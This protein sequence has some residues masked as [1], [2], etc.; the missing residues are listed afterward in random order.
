MTRLAAAALAAAVA[1]TPAALAADPDRGRALYELR[2]G[3][4]HSK[5]VHGRQR[6]VAT[7]FAAVRGW[8]ARWSR[9]LELGWSDEEVVDVAVYLN[10]TYYRHPCPPDVCRV[11]SWGKAGVHLGGPTAFR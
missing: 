9:E 6:R 8:V 11:V 2:C 1:F 7:D 4:C 10:N 3:E 5:S